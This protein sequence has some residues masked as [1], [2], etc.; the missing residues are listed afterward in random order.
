MIPRTFSINLNPSGKPKSYPLPVARETLPP[1]SFIVKYQ[2]PLM[3]TD[4]HPKVMIY[5]EDR[6]LHT[7]V[8]ASNIPKE[9]REMVGRL[10][11]VFLWASR[12]D[13]GKVELHGIAPWQGW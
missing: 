1:G 11:K 8:F 3:S 10:P 2:Q 13:A 5:S 12:N 7:Q 9:I 4:R 6:S